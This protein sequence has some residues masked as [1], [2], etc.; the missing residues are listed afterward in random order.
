MRSSAPRQG[1]APGVAHVA[2]AAA[3]VSLV[4]FDRTREQVAVSRRQGLADA[5]SHVPR[6]ALRH[7]DI[8]VELHAAEAL[9]VRRHEE[10][11]VQPV[12]VSD[13]RRLHERIRLDGEELAAAALLALAA[14]VGHR[15]VLAAGL[16]VVMAAARAADSALPAM[17]DE[18]RLG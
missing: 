6:G 1:L 11:G 7:V 2:L 5:V 14:A 4:H 16:D 9:Q 12:Q 13:V 8:A 18:P 15:R 10:Q 17:R 3:H